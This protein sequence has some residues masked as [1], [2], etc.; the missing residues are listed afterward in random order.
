MT[1]SIQSVAM[2]SGLHDRADF[3]LDVLE[4]APPDAEQG[5]RSM[6]SGGGGGFVDPGVRGTFGLVRLFFIFYKWLKTRITH[7]PSF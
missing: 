1:T 4:E 6:S 5:W 2:L 3:G 7:F